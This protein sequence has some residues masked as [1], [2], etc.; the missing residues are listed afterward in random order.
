MKE[1]GGLIAV[2]TG[3]GT[4]MGR[5]LARALASQGCHVALGDI[6]QDT[7]DEA[8]RLASGDAPEGTRITT[9]LLSLIHI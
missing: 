5:A 1:F 8:A 2:I 3:A 4:G 7:L 9:H 6:R